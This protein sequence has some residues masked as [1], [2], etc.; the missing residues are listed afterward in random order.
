[1]S[2][3]RGIWEVARREL[4]QRS[5]SRTLRISFALVFVLAVGAAV[6]AALES[7]STPTDDVGLVGARAAETAPALR[8]QARSEGRRVRLHRLGSVGAAIKAVDAG[9]VD[10]A[11]VDGSRLIVRASVSGPAV[12]VVQQAVAGR[13]TFARFRDL[14]LTRGQALEATA[15]PPLPVAVLDPEPSE[16]DQALI[17]I[18]AMA[19]FAA[20]VGFGNAVAV[21][22]T[23]EKSSRV[24]ELLLTTMPPRRLLAGKVL[25]IGLLGV[26]QIAITGGAALAAAQVA[27]GAGLPS[28]ATGTVALV[29][30]WFLLGFAFYSVAFAAVG[31]LVSRQEDLS[32]AVM[33]LTLVLVGAYWLSM[34][35]LD[36]GRNPDST[37]AQVIAFV[38]PVAPMIVPSLV[39]SGDMAAAALAAA[40]VLD[41][42]ATIGLIW[43]AARVYER[44][45]LRIGAPVRLR[46]LFGA[47]GGRPCTERAAGGGLATDAHDRELD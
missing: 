23:E 22:V 7:A 2:A 8:L 15:P 45:I 31:A 46:S 47:R 21:S 39:V 17:A 9:S 16:D 6:A 42:V 32:A 35:A 41:V 13:R 25:G 44:A 20:L 43:V 29:V 1:V 38:P 19:L 40:I 34:L 27:G 28:G 33:P 3:W 10:V 24:I 36:F 14:G 11:L 37:L 18:G 4:V 5:R 12:G 26:A 30:L